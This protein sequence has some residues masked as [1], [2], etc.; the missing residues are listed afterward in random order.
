MYF[1]AKPYHHSSIYKSISLGKLNSLRGYYG[2][3]I[4]RVRLV[5][6]LTTNYN[7]LLII[8]LA[9]LVSLLVLTKVLFSSSNHSPVGIL[10]FD[11]IGQC[12]GQTR[13]NVYSMIYARILLITALF[14]A[15]IIWVLNC[16]TLFSELAVTKK[17]SI[18]SYAELNASNRD[19]F[20][21]KATL[22]RYEGVAALQR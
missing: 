15:Y 8:V 1:W 18:S 2:A 14:L 13:N 21:T 9:S 22:N 17:K 5:T 7:Y 12:L 16:A 11:F 19:I 6:I 10:I 4:P 3:A 20:I